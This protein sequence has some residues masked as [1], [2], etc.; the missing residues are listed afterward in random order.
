MEKKTTKTIFLIIILTSIDLLSKYFF[1]NKSLLHWNIFI[2]P[3]FNLGISRWIKI[4]LLL[5]ILISILALIIFI[6]LF[7]KKHIS[8]IIFSI[9]IGW[10]IGNLTDRIFL[11]W[12]RDFISIW[13]FPVFNIADILLNIWII[14]IIIKE[15]RPKK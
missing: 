11:W 15:F 12:V 8:R 9:L 10:T 14:M 3:T 13:N 4:N 6:Y 5:V 1:Y 7:K 2:N